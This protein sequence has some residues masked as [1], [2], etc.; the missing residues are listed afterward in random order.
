MISC[1]YPAFIDQ[2]S[3]SMCGEERKKKMLPYVV[4]S[5]HLKSVSLCGWG[6]DI[7][8]SQFCSFFV[9]LTS[10]FNYCLKIK[11]GEFVTSSTGFSSAL[12]LGSKI[13]WMLFCLR[14]AQ[15]PGCRRWLWFP[16]EAVG[17]GAKVVSFLHCSGPTWRASCLCSSV[18]GAG[19]PESET[20]AKP[21]HWS[22]LLRRWQ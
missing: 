13:I 9:S 18:G 12:C 7:K 22:C 4:S 8:A 3:E 15:E 20:A 21:F 19:K 2:K 5:F 10:L 16:F 11:W 14:W 1:V 17:L 6:I